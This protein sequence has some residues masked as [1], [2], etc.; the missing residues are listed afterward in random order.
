MDGE[1]DHEHEGQ[2]HEEDQSLGATTQPQMTG[3]GDGPCR[4]TQQDEAARL[5]LLT[6][7]RKHDG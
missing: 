1:A 2:G 5:P 4:C 7:A 3:A 6:N